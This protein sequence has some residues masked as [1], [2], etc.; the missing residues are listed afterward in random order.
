LANEAARTLEANEQTRTACAPELAS[1]N[2]RNEPARKAE[3]ERE[4]G[5]GREDTETP[6]FDVVVLPLACNPAGTRR[7]KR[8]E[9]PKQ[10]GK[11]RKTELEKNEGRSLQPGRRKQTATRRRIAFY[12]TKRKRA[13]G[14]AKN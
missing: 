1:C 5:E 6:A 10:A 4:R 12:A 14:S 13:Q 9:T 11:N 8:A 7:E 2:E 3:N